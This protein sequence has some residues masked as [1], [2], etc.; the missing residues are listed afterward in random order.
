MGHMAG[1]ECGLEKED[2]PNFLQQKQLND[3]RMKYIAKIPLH[4]QNENRRQVVKSVT[5]FLDLGGA[6]I[7]ELYKTG[8][9]RIEHRM[10]QYLV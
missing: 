5:E 8:H 4:N 9:K 6:K 10:E 2:A 1:W 3:L 7:N